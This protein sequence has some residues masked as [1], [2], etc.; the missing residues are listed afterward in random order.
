M[1]FPYRIQRGKTRYQLKWQG[2]GEEENTWKPEK[3][4][5]CPD[6]I[7]EYEDRFVVKEDTADEGMDAGKSSQAEEEEEKTSERVPRK[8]RLSL[9]SADS[10]SEK[11]ED[12][13]TSKGK[14]RTRQNKDEDTTEMEEAAAPEKKVSEVNK[15]FSFT[16]YTC[17][18]SYQFY[19]F[20]QETKLNQ[21]GLKEQLPKVVNFIFSW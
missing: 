10:K 20:L 3:N 11:T 6:L 7:Q 8:K 16:L 17:I 13:E 21:M 2:Y 5:N 12:S 1:F 15:C 19:F 4:L 9:S 18:H 14:K